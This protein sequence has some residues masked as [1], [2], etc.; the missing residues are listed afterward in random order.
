MSARAR[1][2]RRGQGSAA[3]RGPDRRGLNAPTRHATSDRRMQLPN[4]DRVGD[5]GVVV[6]GC[7]RR[8]PHLCERVRERPLSA[9]PAR[10]RRWRAGRRPWP[11]LA[12]RRGRGRR[13][14]PLGVEVRTK[15]RFRPILV[16]IRTHVAAPFARSA[17]LGGLRQSADLASESADLDDAIKHA[18]PPPEG[19]RIAT[20]PAGLRPGS[21]R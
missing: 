6:V 2:Q 19:T 10:R 3:W 15:Q 9:L 17:V 1:S 11:E 21:V 20:M 5:R 12:Q 16:Q 13:G 14:R 18:R 7:R 4:L 8:R